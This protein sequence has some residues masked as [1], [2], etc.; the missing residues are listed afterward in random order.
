MEDR[1]KT[2]QDLLVRLRRIE[3]LVRGLH[4]MI[5]EGE[6]RAGVVN[7]LAAVRGALDQ[8]GFML[9]SCRMAECVKMEGEEGQKALEDAMKLFLKLT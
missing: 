3:G 4:R 5:E 1:E 7:Q 8:V 9:L 2:R 6:E